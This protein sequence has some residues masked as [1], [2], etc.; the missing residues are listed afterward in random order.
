M[1]QLSHNHPDHVDELLSAYIDDAVD[2]AERH[3]AANY[4]ETCAACAHE[5]RELRMFRELLR[6]VPNVQPR[7][8]FTL[9]PATVTPPRRLL[10]PTLRWASLV[11]TL[12]FLV[13]VGVDTMAVGSSAGFSTSSAPRVAQNSPPAVPAQSE[14]TGGAAETLMLPASPAASVFEGGQGAAG[15]SGPPVAAE[16]PPTTVVAGGETT[17]GKTGATAG[18]T[19]P[20]V[21][22]YPAAA[23]GIAPDMARSAPAEDSSGAAVGTALRADE[24]AG[25]DTTELDQSAAQGSWWSILTLRFV[26]I[27]LGLIALLLGV[28]ALWTWRRQV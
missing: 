23:G 19:A 22:P 24:P 17:A 6:D 26:E 14:S 7:R 28:A 5:V 27:G 11:A 10:F 8:S 20:Q 12:L 9:D 4:I 16:I 2:L 18:G 25:A 1:E 13:V 3:R 21:P 15:A